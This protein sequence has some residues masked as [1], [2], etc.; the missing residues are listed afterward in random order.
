MSKKLIGFFI[1]IFSFILIYFLPNNSF[2]ASDYTISSYDININVNENNTFDIT[3]TI[4][5]NFSTRKH[6][7]IRKIPLTNTVERLDGS[8]STNHVK[9][10]N[11]EVNNEYTKSTSN[12]DLSIKIGNPDEY[13]TGSQTYIIK[14]TYD[15]GKDPVKDADEFYYNLIG[16]D[17]DTSI[18]NV[19]F[20]IT[21]PKEFDP[22][23][24]GF[25]VGEYGS[26]ENDMLFYTVNGNTITGRYYDILP[27]GNALTIR[28]P[29]PDDYFVG[30][31]TNNTAYYFIIGISIF[32]VFIA[33]ILWV[34]FGKD[35]PV[36]ETVEFYPPNGYNSA[37]IA[38]L[39][40]G[41]ADNEAVISL[42]IYLADKGYLKIE[43]T[44]NNV[45]FA[46][47]KDFKITKLKEYDG[48]N[49]SEKIFFNNLFKRNDSVTSSDLSNSFYI[50]V[51]KI[52]QLLNK[53]TNKNQ[54]FDTKSSKARIFII[55]M[56]IIIFL[57]ITY[58]PFYD[59]G[60]LE[61]LPIALIFPPIGFSVMVSVLLSKS[62]KFTKVFIT[63][64]GLLFGGAPWLFI[65]FPVIS[66]MPIYA[67]TYIIGIICIMAL[68]IFRKLILKR[69]PFGIEILGKI[70]GFK[71]FLE[72]AEKEQL[73]AL[74]EKQPDYFY[75]IL[76]Y[77]YALNVSDKWVKQFES[78]AIEPPRWYYSDTAFT[79]VTFNTFMNNTMSSIDK[80]MTSSPSSSS[81]RSSGGGFSGG[82]S[83]GGGGSSW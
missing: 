68:F 41:E 79:M 69:T 76:P 66:S 2:A 78:I 54:I 61:T 34:L 36:I 48:N 26:A 58:K 43:E 70:R 59:Y 52:K 67:I 17:W 80:A 4:V 74:V 56:I 19:S 47:N 57:L 7:I 31:T 24:L 53:K 5:A 32:F 38:F 20:S 83:G 1:F 10:T 3:E 50:T 55:P 49:E 72:T 23:G 51:N 16:T 11:L 44:E 22:S 35:S 8:K 82:G 25:S 18:S 81:G 30:A 45:L 12:G 42:L 62:N 21:M 37:E 14:Y 60:M 64:W 46:K 33:F 15:I 39:Y 63:F 13:V 9:I 77:T 65:V 71:R 27:A 29:L 75:N 73:E 28:I 40:N 6:G